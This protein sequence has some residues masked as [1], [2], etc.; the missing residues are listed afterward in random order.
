MQITVAYDHLYVLIA[1]I[2]KRFALRI[3]VYCYER[4]HNN[5]MYKPHPQ[6]L[7]VFHCCTQK[8]D[9][10]VWEIKAS[11]KCHHRVVFNECGQ[12]KPLECSQLALFKNALKKSVKMPQIWASSD[13]ER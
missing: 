3:R 13:T 12:D 4:V 9:G 5:Y 2:W 8:K 10:R 6:V 7:P 11:K 1:E